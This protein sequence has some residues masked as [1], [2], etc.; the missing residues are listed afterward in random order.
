[1][2]D[3]VPSLRG[4]AAYARQAMEDKLTEHTRYVD[5]HGVDMPEVQDWHW[6]G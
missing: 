1:M 4:A 2:I 3:Q 5:E 6:P